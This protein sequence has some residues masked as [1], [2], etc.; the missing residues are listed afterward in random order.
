[1]AMLWKPSLGLYCFKYGSINQKATHID[2]TKKQIFAQCGTL[3][4][5]ANEIILLLEKI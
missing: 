5:L 3:Y 4:R 1:M 2:T